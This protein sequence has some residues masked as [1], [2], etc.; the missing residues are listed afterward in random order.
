MHLLTSIATPVMEKMMQ[1]VW[2]HRLWPTRGLA[3]TDGRSLRIIDP[4]QLNTGAGPDFFNAEIELDKEHWVGNIEIHYRASDWMRHGHHNDR[5]YDSVI[6]HVVEKDDMVIPRPGTDG[7][8]PQVTM[9]HA[10]DIYRRYLSLVGAPPADITCCDT[11]ASISSLYAADWLATL[12]FERIYAKSDRVIELARQLDND[13]EE[14]AYITLSRAMG[15]GVNNDAFERLARSLPL[16][17]LRKHANNAK[18]VEALLFGQ[19]SLLRSVGD[20]PDEYMLELA[21]EYRFLSHKYMLTPID[22]RSWK[23]GRM[24]PYNFP[25]RRI[26]TLARLLLYTPRLL[27]AFKGVENEEDARHLFDINLEGY[28]SNHHRFGSD[29]SQMSRAISTDSCRLLIINVIVPIVH[30]WAA[31]NGDERTASQ[32][33]EVLQS[34]PPEHNSIVSAFVAAGIECR[35]AFSSQALIQL[36]REYCERR[37]CIYCRFGHRMLATQPT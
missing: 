14:V 36:R 12:G 33:V 31:F 25:H 13:W 6:L 30:A 17:I 4:G 3:T 37:K 20:I 5:A 24:R 35:D 18:A 11:L 32:V 10:E 23:L 21:D 28:W 16:K 27:S 29:I 26:A 15:F 2:Q 34:L 1:Y 8:I 9:P 22:E 19:A 7:S